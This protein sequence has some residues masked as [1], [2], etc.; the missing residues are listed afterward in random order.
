MKDRLLE[1][2]Y[3]YTRVPLKTTK[4]APGVPRSVIKIP[5][6]T[7]IFIDKDNPYIGKD[8]HDYYSLEALQSAN[9]FWKKVHFPKSRRP[10]K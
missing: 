4:V 7:R 9:D 3:D 10:L 6:A 1:K 8:G 2:Y 5:T